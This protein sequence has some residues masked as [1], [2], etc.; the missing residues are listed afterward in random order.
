[1]NMAIIF[2]L[3]VMSGL[4]IILIIWHTACIYDC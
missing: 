3:L 2:S 4:C 1:L